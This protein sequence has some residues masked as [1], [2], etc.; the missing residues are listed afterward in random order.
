MLVENIFSPSNLPLAQM[1]PRCWTPS[2][3]ALI[4]ISVPRHSPQHS[5]P[6]QHLLLVQK[7]W[8]NR[9]FT[10]CSRHIEIVDE[11]VSD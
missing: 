11:E 1:C 10:C 8:Q 6:C 4:D 3:P 5:M 9:G 2:A 7:E